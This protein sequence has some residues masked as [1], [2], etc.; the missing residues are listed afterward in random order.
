MPL[1][2]PRDTHFLHPLESVVFHFWH[3]EKS[4]SQIL[5]R[6]NGQWRE[7]RDLEPYAGNLAWQSGRC[8]VG[9]VN[10]RASRRSNISPVS[11]YCSLVICYVLPPIR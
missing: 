7:P 1:V 10:T 11:V 2:L 8:S 5:I 3:P 6:L 9:S 4:I